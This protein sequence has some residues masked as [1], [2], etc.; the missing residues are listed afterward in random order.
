MSDKDTIAALLEERRG[1]ELRGHDRRVAEVDEQL[2]LLGFSPAARVGQ[3]AA[4]RAAET[5][6]S[7]APKKRAAPKKSAQ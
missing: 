5:P 7:A 1:L 2:R 6:A 3:A 4:K